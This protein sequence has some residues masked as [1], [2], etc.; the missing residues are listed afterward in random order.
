MKKN[1]ANYTF[2]K[3][4]KTA[5][6]LPSITYAELERAWKIAKY[7]ASNQKTT[8]VIIWM[9]VVNAMESDCEPETSK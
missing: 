3:C 1:L 2:T 6:S 9:D 8:P 5:A 7:R 4:A